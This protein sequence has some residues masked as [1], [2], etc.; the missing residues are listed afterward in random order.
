MDSIGC[1]YASCYD[2]TVMKREFT[3]VYKKEN[4]WYIA[5]VE[6][7]PGAMTQGRTLREATANLK[8]ALQLVLE[9]RCS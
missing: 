3:A 8:D 6:E 2:Y 5:W 1:E 4:G 9:T 7:V